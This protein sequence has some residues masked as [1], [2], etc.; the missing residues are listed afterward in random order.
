MKLKAVKDTERI[1]DIIAKREELSRKII[2]KMGS[3]EEV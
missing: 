3:V 1:A 2:A